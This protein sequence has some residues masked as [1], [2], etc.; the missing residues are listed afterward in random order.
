MADYLDPDLCVIGAGSGGLTVTAAARALD[1]SVVLI[2]R[3]KMGGDCLNYGC[4]PSKSLIAAARR[5]HTFRS[6]AP[7][8]I[9]A[10]E[11]KVNFGRLNEH[12]KTVIATI[13]PHDSVE[14]FE[15]L[16]ATVIQGTASFL[17]RRTVEVDGQRV[18]ARRFVI[19]TGS[20]PAVPPIEG[21][22]DIDFL[23][24]ETIFDLTAKPT[25]LLVIGAGPIGLELAQAYRRLGSQVT[26]FEMAQPLHREDPELSEIALRAVR[27]DGVSIHGGAKVISAHQKGGDVVVVADTG[28]G[29]EEVTGSHLLVAT[30]RLPNIEALGLDAAG[31]GVEGGRIRLGRGLKTTN[32]R[33]YAIGDLAGDMHFTH[34]AGYHAGLVVRNAL[35]R[36]PVSVNEQIIPRATYTDPQIA[37][38]GPTEAE[39]RERFGNGFKVLRWDYANNDRLRTE[40]RS[41]GLLKVITD[42]KGRILG[43][44]AVGPNAAEVIA[45]YSLAVAN[46]LGI[47]AFTKTVMPYPTLNEVTQRIAYEYYR[48]QLSNPWLRRLL[49]LNRLFG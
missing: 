30:G 7:F 18:R 35:F 38:V 37:H 33:I 17:D 47:G 26:V 12:I 29:E 15:G 49:E 16:G 39:A 31:V 40:R 5:A 9:A 32:R 20:R 42:R 22:D 28:S 10:E 44:G 6:S 41:D 46:G 19:A 48:D 24:N 36:L 25:H 1:A 3:S 23:T 43:A 21:L 34:T 27:K 14:R 45:F 2:E 8:G 13:A 4:V 11:P